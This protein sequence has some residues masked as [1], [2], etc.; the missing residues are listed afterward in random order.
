MNVGNRYIQRQNF[1]YPA[2]RYNPFG[3]TGY[4]G[5]YGSGYGQGYGVPGYGGGSGQ[6]QRFGFPLYGTTGYVGYPGYSAPLGGPGYPPGVGLSP[7][8]AGLLGLGAGYLGAELIDHE[9]KRA[10]LY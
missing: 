4:P 8:G 9:S 2:A 3:N 10:Y 1:F 6:F 7:L 5:S